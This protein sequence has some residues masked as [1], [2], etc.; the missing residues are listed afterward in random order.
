[1]CATELNTLLQQ[2]I[3]DNDRPL[4]L[5]DGADQ[6][7]IN[8]GQVIRAMVHRA[9][10]RDATERRSD[11]LN[12]IIDCSFTELLYALRQP[13]TPF[14]I[15]HDSRHYRTITTV[16]AVDPAVAAKLRRAE[17]RLTKSAEI[18]IG[19]REW[20]SLVISFSLAVAAGIVVGIKNW[21]NRDNTLERVFDAFGA[22]S[23]VSATLVAAASRKLD[24]VD[25]LYALAGKRR[26]LTSY[27]E[28]LSFVGVSEE[29]I[30]TCM[31][32]EGCRVPPIAGEGSC[33]SAEPHDGVFPLLLGLSSSNGRANIIM[34]NFAAVMLCKDGT[35]CFR[36]HGTSDHRHL[37]VSEDAVY[38][39]VSPAQVYTAGSSL[40]ARNAQ[41]SAG[42]GQISDLK[43][44]ERS[45]MD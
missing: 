44:S 29:E 42:S 5:V 28:L 10:V 16:R 18:R 23:I 34:G 11:V 14:S 13:Q 3:I 6:H 37:V 32:F 26:F 9:E 7:P 22:A 43:H 15:A 4:L 31:T 1:M 24:V 35:R 17:R 2:R 20:A 33:F 40:N 12:S 41:R 8:A 27:A 30:K 39:L 36:V 38:R 45:H 21:A 19:W 25:L